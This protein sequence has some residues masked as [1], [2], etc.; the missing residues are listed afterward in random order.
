M[1]LLLEA[2]DGGVEGLGDGKNV[3]Q[4]VLLKGL[5]LL[6]GAEEFHKLANTAAEQ[7]EF[8]EDLCWV[9]VELLRFGQLLET[10]LGELVLLDVGIV[11]VNA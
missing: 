3:L 4:V 7:I 1:V 6:D 2:G 9:E 5:E 8:A 11:Q 10:G